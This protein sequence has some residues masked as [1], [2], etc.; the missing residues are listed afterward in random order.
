[1]PC[2][3]YLLSIFYLFF[4]S[5]NSQRPEIGSLPYFHT[6]CGP[7]ANLECT[8]EFKMCFTRLAGNTGRKKSPF[9]HHRTNLSAYMFGN[10]ACIDNRKKNLLNSNTSSRCPGNTVNFGLLTRNPLKFAGVPQ[11]RQQIS[12]VSRLISVGEFGAYLQTST[13]FASWQSYCTAL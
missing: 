8:S 5:P 12:V 10:K 2:S 4:S 1:M 6:W 9:W 11:T 13:G 3:F 7:S